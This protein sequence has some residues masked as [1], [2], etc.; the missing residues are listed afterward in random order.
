M[1]IGT[2]S[3]PPGTE[4]KEDDEPLITHGYTL[5]TKMAA[6]DVLRTIA[7]YAFK[8]LY[9]LNTANL[10]LRVIGTSHH[11]VDLFLFHLTMY[12]Y[13]T[14]LIQLTLSPINP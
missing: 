14:Y 5:V 7:A 3:L 1:T 11:R 10:V 13:I 6:R 8:V 2:L 9:Q 4:Q 12:K